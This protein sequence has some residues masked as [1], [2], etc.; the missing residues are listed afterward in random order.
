MASP[1]TGRP[2]RPRRILW[3]SLGVLGVVVVFTAVWIGV[4]GLLLRSEVDAAV[5]AATEMRQQLEAS[6]FAAAQ[7]SATDLTAHAHSAADLAGDPIWRAAESIP[8]VG[9]NLTA[10]RVVSTQL[11]RLSSRAVVPVLHLADDLDSIWSDGRVDIDSLASA[12]TPLDEALAAVQ[13][14]RRAIAA[15]DPLTLVGPLRSGIEQLDGYLANAEPIVEGAGLAAAT[16]P[17]VLGG[18]GA[19]SILV[20]LQN[21][22]ELRTGGGLTGAF[23][24][25]RADEGSLELV[26]QASSADFPRLSQ[27]ISELPAS[28]STLLDDAVGRYVMNISSPA[29]FTVSAELASDWWELRTGH[30]P[31]TIVS[32]DVPVLAALLA[33]VGPV[34]V[35]GWGQLSSENLVQRLLID[36]Y[37]ALA[38]EDQDI[39]FQS[40]V[41]DVFTRALEVDIDVPALI[42]QLSGPVDEGRV[43]VWSAY[44]DVQ[45][46][47]QDS[48]FAGSQGRQAQAGKG[49]YAVYFNDL[50]GG[51][52]DTYLDVTIDASVA[53]CR[54][55]KRRDIAVAVTLTNTAPA[56]A[57]SIYPAW[58][59]G[60]GTQGVPAGEIGTLVAVSAP[61]GTFRS[62]VRQDGEL[63]YS[64]NGEGDSFVVNQ[65]R[66]DLA[67]GDSETLVFHFIAALPGGLEPQILHTPLLRPPHVTVTDVGCP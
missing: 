38:P 45:A 62:G 54:E 63:V 39:L 49:A 10:A 8:Y 47:L 35:D 1:T 12:S 2:F 36:P 33:V 43:S 48:A 11:D 59:T 31:D 55:D 15:L 46:I 29:D 17:A 66:L 23:A 64:A 57:G 4:R 65:S 37:V 56:D 16:I 27:P 53:A 3:A 20:M 28:V 26:D 13:G 51:K 34:E 21:G 14:A 24:E 52:M 67:P 7:D 42:A 58:L 6:D 50:T 25:L 60:G 41:R 40:V 9:A 19:R 61:P 5:A 22:A 30:R 32:V 44:P 18:D